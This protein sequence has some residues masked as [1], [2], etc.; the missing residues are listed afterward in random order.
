LSDKKTNNLSILPRVLG[1]AKPYKAVFWACFG[2]A[3]VMA[4][5]GVL[6]PRLIEQT[7]D[8]PISQGDMPGLM[9]MLGILVAILLLEGV[10]QYVFSYTTSW[11]GQ[12]VIRDLR[13]R[14]FNHINR[15]N[16]SYFDK[17]PVGRSITRTISDIE[18]INTVFSEGV[19]TIVAD[20]LSLIFVLAIMFYTSWKLTLVCL[21]TLPLLLLATWFFK[22]GVKKSFEAVRTKVADMNTFLQERISGMRIVQIFRA[23]DKEMAKF[24]QIN[25]D[26]TKANL[27]SIFYYSVF[28]PAVEI[29]LAA[30]L[31]LMVWAGTRG[32]LND[33]FSVG[34]LISFP[35]YINMLF[36][37]VRM[38]ADKFN[39]LQMGLVAANRV[40]EVLD[41]QEQL[42][43]SGDYAPEKLRGELS[44]EN[45][46]FKYGSAAENADAEWILNDVSFNVNA[47][48]TLAIVGSTGSGKTTIIS[49]LAKLYEIQ[50]G[51]IS[52]DGTDINE[53]KLSALRRRIAVVL[54]DVF[55]FSGSVFDN[56]TLRDEKF[57]REQIEAAAKTIGAHPFIEKLPGG[58][59]YQV[60]ERGATLSMGQRQLI[61]FVR[62]LVMNPDILIL[63]E[64]TSSIDPET[65]S[66]IQN[67]IETLIRKRTSIII[68]HR[69][70]TIQHADKVLVLSKG[71]VVEFGSP[72][73]LLQNPDGHYR[74]L[75]D[76]QFAEQV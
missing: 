18:T 49:L 13:V 27:D 38:L 31:G 14:V 17:T 37:P 43:Q 60:M 1:L 59:D 28:F 3:V 72:K 47:G 68:A 45:V 75:Y 39:T 56:I 46:H 65:E 10:L 11:L 7:V 51:K 29:F 42:E 33:E 48:E 4:P 16:L 8:G 30:S 6:R 19:I 35:L 20:I 2:L 25:H 15:L 55:L 54:Q 32:V 58:Y 5:V 26:Y 76:M 50:Q 74:K 69:L 66:V 62:A 9:L 21:A 63:D 52:I 34:V 71:K 53:Y 41:N 22:E 36:R 70:S 61:S 73:T 12:S 40:F 57:S 23:E 67:A 64:A 44:F 24:K